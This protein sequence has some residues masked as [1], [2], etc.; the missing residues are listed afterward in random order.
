MY[1]TKPKKNKT[2]ILET[3]KLTASDDYETSLYNINYF[4]LIKFIN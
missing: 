2:S 3:V 1:N 4:D